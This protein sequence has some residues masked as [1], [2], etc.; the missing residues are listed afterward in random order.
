M[1]YNQEL[2][3]Y[4]KEQLN[5]GHSLEQIKNILIQKGWREAEVNEAINSV[6]RVQKEHPKEIPSEGAPGTPSKGRSKKKIILLIIAV[7]VIV[8]LLL[9]FGTLILAVLLYQIGMFNPG[10][11][12]SPQAIG[13]NVFG[14]PSHGDWEYSGTEFSIKLP[15]QTYDI[16]ITQATAE[17]KGVGSCDPI[18]DVEIPAGRNIELD[19]TGCEASTSGS[20]YSVDIT[21]KYTKSDMPLETVETGTVTGVVV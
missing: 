12:S 3:N 15:S 7:L 20:S 5:S 16:E 10:A 8:Y 19:F 6:Q 14:K 1:V 9:V 13:F 18:T 17:V 2:A 11:L 21:I 4:I